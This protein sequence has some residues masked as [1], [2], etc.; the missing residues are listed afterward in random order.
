MKIKKFK[1]KKRKGNVFPIFLFIIVTI[2]GTLLL[3]QNTSNRILTINQ[4]GRFQANYVAQA[5]LD[6]ILEATQRYPVEMYEAAAKGTVNSDGNL[7][8]QMPPNSGTSWAILPTPDGGTATV[9]IELVSHLDS[10][11]NIAEMEVVS[12]AVYGDTTFVKSMRM[13]VI[14][15]T[16]KSITSPFENINGDKN[17][18]FTAVPTDLIGTPQY[19]R[20]KGRFV[21]SADSGNVYTSSGD[22]SNPTLSDAQGTEILLVTSPSDIMNGLTLKRTFTDAN[23]G[24]T[25]AEKTAQNIWATNLSSAINIDV[26]NDSETSGLRSEGNTFIGIDGGARTTPITIQ[27]YIKVTG[28]KDTN[29]VVDATELVL[30]GLTTPELNT[31]EAKRKGVITTSAEKVIIKN[32][33]SAKNNPENIF[34]YYLY[35][36][37]ATVTIQNSDG[38]TFTGSI[39]AKQLVVKDNDGNEMYDSDSTTYAGQ[40]VTGIRNILFSDK[41]YLGDFYTEI[42]KKYEKKDLATLI[43]N[44]ISNYEFIFVEY[45]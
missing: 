7:V 12:T 24:T 44:H 30:D 22:A 16:I 13:Y 2:F 33:P 25:V 41:N 34:D 29:I 8:Y 4:R 40:R 38:A 1:L 37:N 17:D 14:D 32:I 10:M 28:K 27:D 35:A 18:Y 45:E 19:P 6:M 39:V 42:G 21:D 36:P 43:P 11:G 5:G 20:V 3:L 15:R 26:K 23:P 31:D 9:D